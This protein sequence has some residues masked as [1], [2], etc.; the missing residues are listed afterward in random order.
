MTIKTSKNYHQEAR[1]CSLVLEGPKLRKTRLYVCCL[2]R[3]LETMRTEEMV[4]VTRLTIR[5]M[6]LYVN[7][8]AQAPRISLTIRPR[9]GILDP[10][11]FNSETPNRSGRRETT[12]ENC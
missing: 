1:L 6:R 4:M 2:T 10:F 11:I 7:P 8:R 5:A 12:A 9:N 3:L